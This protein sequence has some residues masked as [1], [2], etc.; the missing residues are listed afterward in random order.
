MVICLDW[1]GMDRILEIW[2]QFGNKGRSK[3]LIIF[4]FV[5]NKFRTS[6]LLMKIWMV[7]DICQLYYIII[8]DKNCN[9]IIAV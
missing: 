8:V 1:S 9:Y 5:D 4:F 7:F 6:Y 3:N 2:K